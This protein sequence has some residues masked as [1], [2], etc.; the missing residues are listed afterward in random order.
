MKNQTKR[1][2]D[3]LAQNKSN[4]RKKQRNNDRSK[5]QSPLEKERAS[6]RKLMRT[7][8]T[9][10][11]IIRAAKKAEALREAQM[12]GDP[13][14][15]PWKSERERIKYNSE[16]F[17]NLTVAESFATAYCVKIEDLELGNTLPE[18]LTIGSVVMLKIKSITKKGGVVFDSGVHKDNFLTRN[19]LAAFEHLLKFLPVG[20]IPAKVIEITPHGVVVDV[21]GAM[22]DE[23][24]LPIIA[25]PWIQ[26]KATGYTPVKVKNLKLVRGGYLGQAVIPN[27][28]EFVGED[29]VVDAFVPGSQIVQNTTDNFEQFDGTD[30]DT[31]ITAWTP[32]PGNK[33]M[34]LICSAKNLIKHRGNLRLKDIHSL[35]C[36]QGEEWYEFEK[37]P[38]E[39]KVTGV[40]NS[41][42]KCGVFVEIPDLEITGMIP[43]KPEELVNFRAGDEIQVNLVD[44]DEEQYYNE[45]VGQYQHLPAFEIVD[46]AIKRVNI[47]PILALV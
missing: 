7:D 27:I 29:F 23:F 24:I 6:A 46:G 45:S 10:W 28:S 32:K 14:D 26:N 21:F 38:L 16:Q 30:V 3:A 31:F 22:L 34:S 37:T 9:V 47:K 5:E 11:D 41:S 36:E 19:N 33:G 44:F 12:Y 13:L 43:T 17:K 8:V 40:I 4:Q 1:V 15:S 39:G 35:W 18:Q 2:E 20:Q 25:R 42:K